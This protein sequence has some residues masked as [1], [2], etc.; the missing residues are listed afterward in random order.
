MSDDTRREADLLAYLREQFA[1]VHV[2]L[3]R[4]EA[5]ITEIKARLAAVELHLRR[6]AR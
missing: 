3:D 5:D 4:I 1:L 2:R 6:L